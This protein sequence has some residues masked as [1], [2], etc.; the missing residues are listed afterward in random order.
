MEDDQ[1]IS[2]YDWRIS[3]VVA[4]KHKL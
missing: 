4:G 1:G 2:F 3:K